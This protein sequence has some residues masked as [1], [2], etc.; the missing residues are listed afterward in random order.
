M[1]PEDF[2]RV[3]KDWHGTAA[4]RKSFSAMADVAGL[5][6][7]DQ[8]NICNACLPHPCSTHS[9]SSATCLHD[10][11]KHLPHMAFNVCSLND[12]LPVAT[13]SINMM[14]FDCPKVPPMSFRQF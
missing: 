5:H 10:V 2:R 1:Q 13:L 12:G 6:H 4:L 9:S 14:K 8:H 3:F 7:S 11:T